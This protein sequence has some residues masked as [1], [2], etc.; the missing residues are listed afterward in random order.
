MI[1]LV[2]TSSDSR[3]RSA[4]A[5]EVDL[6][7]QHDMVSCVHV[8]DIGSLNSLS[9]VGKHLL[10]GL[11]RERLGSLQ[12]HTESSVPDELRDGTKSVFRVEARSA[13]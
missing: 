4:P 13:E 9:L 2:Y 3:S 8:F 7:N 5:L 11:G 6:L 10:D 12:G 1:P